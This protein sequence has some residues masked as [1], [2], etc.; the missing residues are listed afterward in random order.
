MKKIIL[1]VIVAF[2][3]TGCS[4]NKSTSC[5]ATLSDTSDVEVKVEFKAN[6]DIV[7]YLEKETIINISNYSED[8]LSN[9]QKNIENNN[10]TE[11]YGVDTKWSINEKQLIRLDKIDFE[12]ASISSLIE[13]KFIPSY[14]ITDNNIISYKELVKAFQNHNYLIVEK[15]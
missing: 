3:L 10:I 2:L 13:W 1:I 12:K 14:T 9:M 5:I 11:I 8:T 6:N 4:K 15:E 7:N